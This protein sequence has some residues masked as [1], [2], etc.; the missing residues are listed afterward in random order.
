[1]EQINIYSS[2]GYGLKAEE[3]QGYSLGEKKKDT[4]NNYLGQGLLIRIQ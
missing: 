3:P 1:M 2:L 4:I